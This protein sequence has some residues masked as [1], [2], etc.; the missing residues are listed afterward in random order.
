MSIYVKSLR[1]LSRK[2]AIFGLSALQAQSAQ[3]PELLLQ[4]LT[5]AQLSW[6]ALTSTAQQ[7]PCLEEANSL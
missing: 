2:A 1:F 6:K 5:G 3:V 7:G 4:K